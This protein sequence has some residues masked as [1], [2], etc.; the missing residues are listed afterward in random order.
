MMKEISSVFT[1]ISCKLGQFDVTC[2]EISVYFHI[3][4]WFIN[5]TING[6]YIS[7]FESAIA[8]L[9]MIIKCKL[10][11]LGEVLIQMLPLVTHMFRLTTM[12]T[13]VLGG[14]YWKHLGQSVNNNVPN[15]SLFHHLER[16]LALTTGLILKYFIAIKVFMFKMLYLSV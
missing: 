6:I 1:N 8:V 10:P 12:I 16:I 4:M 5:W 2:Q 15:I 7:I 9:S 11:L 13:S 14:Y 3:L